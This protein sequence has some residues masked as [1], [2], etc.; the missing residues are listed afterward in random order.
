MAYQINFISKYILCCFRLVG[1][2]ILVVPL[3]LVYSLWVEPNWLRTTQKSIEIAGIAQGQPIKIV[4]LSDLHTKTFSRSDY[5]VE[6]V[7]SQ[8]PD[9]IVITGDVFDGRWND[10][11]YIDSYLAPLKA[12]YG[13]YFVYGNN[14]YHKRVDIKAFS[15]HLEKS[16]YVVLQNSNIKLDIR[17]QTLWLI[18]V[19]DPH[20]GRDNLAK[21]LQGVGDGPKVL[22][23]HS[24]EIIND[25]VKEGIDL[26]L[27]GHT[28]GGQ[29]R[30]PGLRNTIVN[31]RSGY[32]EYLR[33]L[34]QVGNTQMYVN[35]GIGTTR[36]P[37]RLFVPPEIAV[38]DLQQARE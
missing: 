4:H 23:A 25:A 12:T 8:K 31:V 5:L 20:T 13:K 14:E 28:H 3:I 18:G 11:N 36:L 34:Y 26:V 22:L 6:K 29:M 35:R 27:V 33:G 21:A 1:L 38:F 2:F 7:N 24:P 15:T 32:E 30:L 19:D 9:I 17:N 10:L 16:G 37:M